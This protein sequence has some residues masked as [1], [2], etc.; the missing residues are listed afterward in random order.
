MINVFCSHKL[1]DFI[2]IEKSFNIEASFINDWNGHLF[3]VAGKK[4]II[5]VNK[6]TLY[7]FTIMDILKKDLMNLSFLFIDTLIKQLERENMLTRYFENYLR[8]SDQI[9]S[10][11]TTDNDRKT[12]G[13]MNDFIYQVK[14]FYA[15]D[16]NLEMTRNY[17]WFNL[18]QMP[19]G[20]LSYKTPRESMSEH[21]KTMA[22]NK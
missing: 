13:S 14:S 12:I 3:N 7:S 8:N 6:K 18:N 1:G 2:N 5:F 10:F 11:C 21:I 20:G 19:S 15:D 22:N 4:W 17:V 9:V 16:K